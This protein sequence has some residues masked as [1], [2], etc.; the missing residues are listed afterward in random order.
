MSTLRNT[1]GTH[2]CNGGGARDLDLLVYSAPYLKINKSLAIIHN[3]YHS[4]DYMRMV[5]GD[6]Y[7]ENVYKNSYYHG[8]IYNKLKQLN[9]NNTKCK[10]HNILVESLRS[11]QVFR[12]TN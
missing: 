9:I 11:K 5:P 1:P 10:Q 2:S 3:V 7:K 4:I 12:K 8:K 6:K